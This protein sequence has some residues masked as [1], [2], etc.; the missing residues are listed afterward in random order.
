M[1]WRTVINFVNRR[2]DDLYPRPW[3]NQWHHTL[4]EG[5]KPDSPDD[6]CRRC[7]STIHATAR[8]PRGCAFCLRRVFPW[9]TLTRLT[10]YDPVMATWIHDLKFQGQWK[11]ATLL[12]QQL[13]MQ[14]PP[15]ANPART[16]ICPVPLHPLRQIQRGYNQSQLL[17]TT[18]GKAHRLRVIS[19][20]RKA[21]HTDAQ[22]SLAPTGRR[23]NVRGVFTAK[24]INLTGYDILLVDDVKT[25]GTTLR[26]CSRLL[27]QAGAQRVDAAVLT[28]ADPQQADF[29]LMQG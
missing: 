22:S 25:T 26:L 17:A 15:P 2:L 24:A 29:Q 23:S 16:L 28:V 18:I 11:L 12:G 9:T 7:G 10:A 14:I 1:P 13:A 21:R 5:W 6:Y 27:I 20:L 19:L 3:L 4:G 8:T